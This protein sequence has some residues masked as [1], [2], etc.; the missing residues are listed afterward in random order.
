MYHW[1]TV[2]PIDI[3]FVLKIS[4]HICIYKKKK[5]QDTGR[6]NQDE[7]NRKVKRRRDLSFG[8]YCSQPWC[9]LY[10]ISGLQSFLD[11][12][13]P[14]RET[15]K[16]PRKYQS[17]QDSTDLFFLFH[18]VLFFFFFFIQNVCLFFVLS[19]Y[20]ISLFYLKQFSIYLKHNNNYYIGIF[21]V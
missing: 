17:D 21:F 14:P 4:I 9:L 11:V 16:V 2:E 6:M 19:A 12:I 13:L 8:S 15:I 18:H 3:V 20:S 7:N 5:Y 1:F 10:T